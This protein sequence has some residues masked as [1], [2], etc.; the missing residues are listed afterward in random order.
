MKTYTFTMSRTYETIFEIEAE[1]YGEA[2]TKL[3]K[4][5]DRYAVEMEQCCVINEEIKCTEEKAEPPKNY[6]II[7]TWNGEG[8]S[9]LNTAEV[10]EFQDDEAAQNHLRQL[11]QSE[12]FGEDLDIQETLGALLY[13]SGHDSGSYVFLREPEKIYGLVIYANVNEI[14]TILSAKEWRNHVAAAIKQAE[15]EDVCEIDITEK[16]FF[17]GAY[18]SD[19]DYQFIRF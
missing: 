18:N 16:N 10:L 7:S 12:H 19:Y 6:A 4:D 1:N 11:F 15:P 9:Y 3:H 2:V 5:V 13:T 14:H 8:Y 17:I